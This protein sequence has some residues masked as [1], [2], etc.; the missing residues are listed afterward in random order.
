MTA[1]NRKLVRDLWQ[2]KGQA[3]AIC[4]VIACGVATFVMSLCTL[5]SLRRAQ[6]AYYERY[7]FAQVFAHLKRA[8]D[9]LAARI[10]EIP[11]VWRVQTRVVEHVTLDVPGLPEPATGR[12][13][14]IPDRPGRADLNDRHLRSGRHVEPGR[15]GEV[16]VS[17][18]FAQA[19]RLAPGDSLRAVL[20]GRLQ[21]LRI[22]GVAL[23]PE[24]IYQLREGDLLPDDRRFGVFWMGHAQMAAAFDMLGAFND[25]SLT[26]APGAS[27]PEVIRRLDRLLAPH[28][29]LGAFGRDDQPSH[30]F[31]SN[32]LKELR[33]MALV[34]PTIFL[35]VSAFLLHVVV[36]RLV[37]TQRE[38]IAALK[39]FG[40]TRYEVGRHY[41]GMVLLIVLAGV[42]L[43]T[44]VGARLG[45]GVTEMYTRFFRFPVFA[46]DL[47]P[48]VVALAL[49][50]SCAVAVAGTLG[51]V[52]LAVRLPPAEAMRP[53]PPARF[54]PTALERVGLGGLLSPAARMV[55]R[56]LERQ[57]VRAL[58]SALGI[59]L[60]VAVLILGNFMVDALDYVMESQF[61]VAQRQ[62]V[63][64]GF[65]EPTSPRVLAE[66]AHLPGVR[67]CEPLRG[68]PARI[69]S[70]H[71]SRRLG[72]QGLR[73]DARLYRVM[74]IDR[75]AVRL[76]PGGV[77]VSAKLAEVLGVGVGDRVTVEVL[78]GRRPVL[79][80]PVT[81]LVKDFAGVSAY[82]DLGAVH[83]LMEEGEL[84]TG[85]FLA[86][87]GAG[88]DK[89]FTRLKDTPRAAS[90]S[91]KGATLMSFRQTVAENLL[92]MRL[93]NVAFAA[94]IAFGV[95]YNGARIALSERAREL[96]TLRVMG[97]YRSEISLV[98]LGE[99]AVVTLAA[100]PLGLLLGRA[101]GGMVIWVAYDT[102]LFRIPLII[103][104][105][106]YAFAAAVTVAAAFVSAL[107][108]RRLLDRLDL[109]AV[110][111][112]KE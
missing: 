16:L 80:V 95:V 81:G 88:L 2:M 38:Q 10:A 20:N 17:E 32:E 58:L 105:S 103:G 51:A 26:L 52:Y 62:D 57:P 21:R 12:L 93:F 49:L 82:M 56:H 43:G 14:S 111:K 85:A 72:I 55:L 75:R 73:P 3:V 71:R 83:R 78:E 50:V 48:G 112:S 91:L 100:V 31:V 54:G 27:E 96:A 69:R 18:G 65:A 23:S 77:V 47:D 74:D 92:R 45:R 108:V 1:L 6:E 13:V 67:A 90:V 59:A 30:K 104:R 60:A 36:S 15:D 66:L 53:E 102:E 44:A 110:L 46:F 86:A 11:G 97:F 99:L 61:E 63:T 98:L 106:T 40:Y 42:A 68:V 89:L 70:G 35:L 39:A 87:D 22:V 109:V 4:L 94:V 25:V 34:V 7:R 107:A 29:G 64:V 41:L 33:G 28:G 76:P 5:S 79:R 8:P 19:H 24:Y 84:V 37:Q 101:L 9:A